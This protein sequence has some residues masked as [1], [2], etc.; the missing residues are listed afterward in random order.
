MRLVPACLFLLFRLFIKKIKFS[1]QSVTVLT[2]IIGIHDSI[3]LN[4]YKRARRHKVMDAWCELSLSKNKTMTHV[5]IQVKQ[6]VQ[7]V[8]AFTFYI[9]TVN[10]EHAK[11]RF[12]R[13]LTEFRFKEGIC[14][15]LCLKLWFQRDWYFCNIAESGWL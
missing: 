6:G 10:D 9:V 13:K 3:H 14:T 5:L 7:G 2:V 1:L 12:K 15:E 11:P 4:C 8:Q